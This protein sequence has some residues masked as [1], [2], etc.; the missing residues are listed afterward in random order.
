MGLLFLLG[1]Y[2][3]R[4][5]KG[6]GTQSQK[7]WKAMVPFQVRLW[8]KT[9]RT[10][11]RGALSSEVA[12]GNIQDL[13]F[14]KTCCPHQKTSLWV[15]YKHITKSWLLSWNACCLVYRYFLST[16]NLKRL[17]S[18]NNSLEL[19]LKEI[20]NTSNTEICLWPKHNI[21]C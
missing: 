18:V 9:F 6:R 2:N 19:S 3:H 11:C 8:V 20:L 7:F 5:I 13:L 10:C 21:G 15:P 1:E 14:Q 16:I 4:N 12:N 17:L